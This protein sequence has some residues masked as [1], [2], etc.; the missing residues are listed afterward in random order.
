MKTKLL[1]LILTI[2]PLTSWGKIIPDSEITH[3]FINMMKRDIPTEYDPIL[4]K[5]VFT[6]VPDLSSME[7]SNPENPLVYLL[8][9]EAGTD[10]YEVHIDLNG[11]FKNYHLNAILIVDYVK[12]KQGDFRYRMI[13]SNIRFSEIIGSHYWYT[14]NTPFRLNTYEWN[15]KKTYY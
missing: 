10:Y 15:R 1:A 9:L 13:P 5:D 2:T 14:R 4:N 3:K 6:Y 7:I 11:Y 8:E 12:T